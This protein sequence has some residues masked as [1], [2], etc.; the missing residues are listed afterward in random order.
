MITVITIILIL[1]GMVLG[2][3]G[4]V[5]KK[6]A[7]SRAEAEIAALSTALESY[8]V[9]NGGYPVSTD[10]SA[11]TAAAG[12]SATAGAAILYRELS[13]DTDNNPTN[14]YEAKTYMP[15]RAGM[16]RTNA[17][18]S[19]RLVDPFGNNYVYLS[20]NSTTANTNNTATFD[21]WSTAGSATNRA[22]WITNW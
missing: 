1:A 3:S 19:I 7:T 2:I 5:Q 20:G 4:Y 14:G 18:A 17:D 22:R 9:D 8:K 16:L 12:A 11:S 6:G 15:F 13:G 10:V 21:L